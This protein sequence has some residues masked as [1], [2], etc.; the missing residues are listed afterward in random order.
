MAKLAH[1]TETMNVMQAQL[2]EF[3]STITK[4]TSTKIKFY[5][6]GCGSKLTHVSKTCL[7]KKTVHKEEVYHK[8]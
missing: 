8:K 6:W 5:C 1:M 4:P 7:T 3:S 2:N